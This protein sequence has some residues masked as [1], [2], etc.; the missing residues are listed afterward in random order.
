M[1]RIQ[2]GEIPHS[3]T[4]SK[5]IFSN[6][7]STAAKVASGSLKHRPSI[8]NEPAIS[9]QTPNTT[10]QTTFYYPESDSHYHHTNLSTT[11]VTPTTTTTSTGGAINNNQNLSSQNQHSNTIELAQSSLSSSASN[12][13]GNSQF[14]IDSTRKLFRSH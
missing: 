7:K 10:E 9:F 2:A 14:Y 8:T 4:S 6:I 5:D 1:T 13:I 11:L 3:Y 12:E